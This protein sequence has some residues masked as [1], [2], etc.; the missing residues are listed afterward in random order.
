MNETARALLEKR[1]KL[2]TD[3]REIVTRAEGEGRGLN[4]EEETRYNK[5]VDDA[6][7]LKTRSDREQAL[8]ELE[9]ESGRTVEDPGVGRGD[10]Q[11]PAGGDRADSVYGT[12]EYR[13]AFETYLRA[14]KPIEEMQAL[15]ELRDLQADIADKGGD[16][17]APQQMVRDLI[18]FIDDRVYL[19]QWSEV[20]SAPNAESLGVPTLDADPDDADWTSE[21]ATGNEDTAM[22]FGKRELKPQP[23]AK[24]IKVSKKLLRASALPIDRLVRERLGYKFAVTQEKAFLTGSGANEPLGIFTASTQGLSTARDIQIGTAASGLTAEELVDQKYGL[25]EAYWPAA[26]WLM[27]RDIM[28][29]VVKIR[30]DSGGAGTGFWMFREARNSG[31]PDRILN[32]PVFMSE[33]AP[34][35]FTATS[36]VSILGDF[37][38]G[39]WIADALNMDIQVLTE[40]YAE[41][42]Q[43]GYIG[44]LETDAMPVLEE[45]F[46]RGQLG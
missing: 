46:V 33:F 11:D 8:A 30:D 13:A 15:A 25:K 45:A 9:T 36:Y 12:T 39:Y 41:A 23:C 27:H 3:A 2:I 44:R 43:N 4:S 40:L 35:T 32:I 19:R 31:E 42:N 26:R 37:K 6:L 16:T 18:K 21:L 38:T 5:M 24:R 1:N 22:K 10:T 20:I 17:V 29:R 28:K 34:N 7:D 14:T